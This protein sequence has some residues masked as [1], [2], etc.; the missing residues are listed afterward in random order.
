M[1]ADGPLDAEHLLQHASF[2]RAV[3]RAAL[4]GDDLVEDVM[5][6]T[7]VAALGS[8]AP[9]R[10]RLRPW[11]AGVARNQARSML[12]KRNADRR[13]EQRAA[14]P[15]RIPPDQAVLDRLEVEHRLVRAVMA[16]HEPFRTPLVL[17]YLDELP[18][19]VIAV[20]LGIPVNT[21]RS[22]VQR[23]LVQL[24]ERLDGEQRG[25]AHRWQLALL[26]LLEGPAGLGAPVSAAAGGVVM[27]KHLVVSAAILLLL[28]GGGGWLLTRSPDTPEAEPEP[29]ASAVP[30]ELPGEAQASPLPSLVVL[31]AIPPRDEPD[32]AP[33]VLPPGGDGAGDAA[34]K[35]LQARMQALV[36]AIRRDVEPTWWSRGP[37]VA[38][39]EP[40][41]AVLIVRAPLRVLDAVDAYLQRLRIGP[42][43]TAEAIPLDVQPLE[44]AREEERDVLRGILAREQALLRALRAWDE[45]NLGAARREATGVLQTEPDNR[46]AQD[47]VHGLDALAGGAL[48][49]DVERARDKL[50]ARLNGARG[51]SRLGTWAMQWPS[52]S[53]WKALSAAREK[54]RTSGG[55]LEAPELG[56]VL[57]QGSVTLRSQE[58][59]LLDLVR[60]LQIE[61]G[62]AVSV[63]VELHAE[64]GSLKLDGV[65]EQARSLRYLLDEIVRKLPAGW[66][67]RVEYEQIVIGRFDHDGLVEVATRLRYFD[68][69]DLL[70]M[71]PPD[72]SGDRRSEPP[73][74]RTYTSDE[75]G[76]K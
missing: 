30:G 1:D 53:T 68:V 26:P 48:A 25:R 51:E 64:A 74:P 32:T 66:G 2:V 36:Q 42:S 28:A 16:L 70:G 40:H 73:V 4:R 58:E 76:A 65:E 55:A 57:E 38:T 5:Q 21:V 67:W 72:T 19:R 69:R 27:A 18:P 7:W 39:L 23:G 3:A 9:R 59:S 50:R 54:A 63:P 41:N 52:V 17:R 8:N 60:R 46:L 14:R 29:V 37:E 11:L 31:P 62:V 61:S 75:V 12:R 20:R 34:S 71:E 56:A 13:Q 33:P 47:L 35:E 49:S 6:E 24:R 45:A 44:A 43:E 22:R 15:E 10:G